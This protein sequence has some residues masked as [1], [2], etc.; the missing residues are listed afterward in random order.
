[1]SQGIFDS[2]YETYAKMLFRLAMTHL[3]N[4][5]DAEDVMQDAFF[6]LIFRA[7]SFRDNE[8]EKRWLIR[9]TVNLC[10]DRQKSAW[11]QKT[12]MPGELAGYAQEPEEKELAILIM[13]LP[14]KY[15]AAVHLHYSEGY[16]IAEIAKMMNLTQSAVKMRL[17]RGRKL[18]KLECEE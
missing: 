17:S 11:K 3:G 15:R 4:S 13:D 1:M 18:L 5:A 2:K 6:R 10:R 14:E 7:P 12:D 16:S 8:H 9:V